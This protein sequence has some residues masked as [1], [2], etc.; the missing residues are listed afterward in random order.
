MRVL[1]TGKGAGYLLKDRVAGEDVLVDA[2]RTV[3]AGGSVVDPEVVAVLTAR[4]NNAR[5]LDA[6]SARE[7]EVLGLMAQGR[8][9]LRRSEERRVGKECRSRWSPYH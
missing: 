1:A 7:R 3:A 4:R 2:V 8:S 6:L 5:Q 9:N